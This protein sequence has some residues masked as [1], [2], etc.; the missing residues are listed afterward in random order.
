[1]IKP[2]MERMTVV[3]LLIVLTG[4]IIIFYPIISNYLV[5][6][7]QAEIIQDYDTNIKNKDK[8]HLQKE[9]KAA[10]EYNNNL[11][12]FE[13]EDPFVANSG[14]AISDNYKEILN[15]ND[16]MAYIEIL[17]IS[18]KL[19]IYHGTSNEVLEKGVGHMEQ[20]SF[21]IGSTTGNCVLTGHRG[22][23]SAKLFTDLD[24]LRKGDKFIISVL[25]KK[26]CYEVDYITVI[27]PTHLDE[28]QIE[29]GKDY[30]SLVTCTPYGVNTHRLIVRGERCEYD[31]DEFSK[32]SVAMTDFN[33]SKFLIAGVLFGLLFIFIIIFIGRKICKGVNYEK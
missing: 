6:K 9:W 17:K 19:P 18:V 21:P 1:M 8:E 13:V 10:E 24:K 11:A 28:L 16:A 14:Y 23:P 31:L 29:S 4:I 7:D 27:D 12:G 15:D 30:V 2:R 3:A 5:Q 25:D 26:L 20:T 33:L 22:L 32:D